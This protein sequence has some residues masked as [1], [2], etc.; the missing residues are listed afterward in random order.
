MFLVLC[1]D[2][3]DICWGIDGRVEFELYD[4]VLRDGV[5]GRLVVGRVVVEAPPN[6]HLIQVILNG[7]VILV[8][9]LIKYTFSISYSLT[10]NISCN[11]CNHK[12]WGG[13]K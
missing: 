11:G 5:G 13:E 3:Q 2:A 12:V 6:S 10:R 7:G 1:L 8:G 4:S 9:N